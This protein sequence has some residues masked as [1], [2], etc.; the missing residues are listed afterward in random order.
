MS[1]IV[2]KVGVAEG[3]NV[4]VRLAVIVRLKASVNDHPSVTFPPHT[5]GVAEKV[6]LT[7]PL[8]VQLAV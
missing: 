8:I 3:L 1:A 5:P 6:E 2:A 7:D 4:I